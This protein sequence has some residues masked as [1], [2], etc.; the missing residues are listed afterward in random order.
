MPIDLPAAPEVWDD[1]EDF[2]KTH[3]KLVKNLDEERRLIVA[4]ARLERRTGILIGLGL[5][6][7]AILVGLSAAYLLDAHW[8]IACDGTASAV[9][10]G[11]RLIG[12]A[13]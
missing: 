7:V 8:P 11:A 2:K 6:A 3:E 4:M 13:L 5:A 10:C 12:G 1:S 9:S